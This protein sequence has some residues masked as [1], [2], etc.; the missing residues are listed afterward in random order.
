MPDDQTPGFEQPDIEQLRH[1]M[2]RPSVWS[3]VGGALMRF[4]GNRTV[5]TIL[6]ALLIVAALAT[7]YWAVT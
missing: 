2:T 4:F 1:A 7:G 5:L 6:L 3:R